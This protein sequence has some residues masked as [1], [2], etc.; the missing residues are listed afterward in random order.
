MQRELLAR[1]L[2]L[3][4]TLFTGPLVRPAFAQVL[5]QSRSAQP[6]T[7]ATAMNHLASSKHLAPNLDARSIIRVYNYARVDPGLLE[8]AKKVAAII[9]ENVGVQTA[10]VDCSVSPEGFQSP[11]YAA[12]QSPMGPA[13]LVLRILPQRMAEKL[14]SSEEALGSAQLCRESEPACELIVFSS[15]ID[16]LA[17][18]GYRAERILGHVIAHEVAHVLIGAGHSD[19]GI[20]RG[21]WSRHDLQ[22]ISWGLA[23][24]FTKAQSTQL[25]SA[26][27]R[28]ITSSVQEVARQTSS[29]AR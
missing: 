5:S 8:G 28:R 17:S 12:C 7:Q 11:A 4:F 20:M 22:C 9:F 1:S 29:A 2:A 10:W 26:V 6:A 14:R 18:K 21:E 24:H 23:L 19:E 27:L 25:R 3:G 16:D 13:D 15:R